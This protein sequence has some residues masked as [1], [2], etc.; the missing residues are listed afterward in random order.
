D[1]EGRPR[2][3]CVLNQ[4]AARE[5]AILV[6]GHNFGCGSSR[7]HAPW[8][9]AEFGVRAIISTSFADIFRQNA[10]KNGLVPVVLPAGAHAELIAEL[11]REPAATITV[12][13]V[14]TTVTLPGGHT[15]TFPIDSF[16]RECLLNGVDEL[17]FVLRLADEIARYEEQHEA[18]VHTLNA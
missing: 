5:A 15:R 7:E 3:D 14:T 8:A 18:R 6:A 2:P 17:G 12:D 9:L 11:A 4:P 10:L 1:A 13:L 16:A